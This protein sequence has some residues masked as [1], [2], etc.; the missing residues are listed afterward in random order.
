MT[1]VATP[2]RE[3]VGAGKREAVDVGQ[4]DVEH[5]GRDRVVGRLAIAVDLARGH[6]ADRGRVIVEPHHS[7]VDAV[8][9]EE[10]FRFGDLPRKP[11]RPRAVADANR[12][13]RTRCECGPDGGIAGGVWTL[14]YPGVAVISDVGPAHRIGIPLSNDTAV[15]ADQP[16]H[17]LPA[18]VGID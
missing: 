11:T 4:V 10:A 12:P 18:D 3:G 8:L 5:D 17:P 15:V 14:R 13:R 9:R 16:P 6:R 2:P 1:P 7:N